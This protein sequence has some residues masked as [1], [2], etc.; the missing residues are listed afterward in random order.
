MDF[1]DLND[2]FGGETGETNTGEANYEA[3]ELFL[4]TGMD[5]AEANMLKDRK[6]AVI[7]LVDCS[8][9]MF[10]ANPHNPNTNSSIDQILK[11]A[12]SFMKSKI[13]T[14]DSDKIGLVLYG[15]QDSKNPLSFNNIYVL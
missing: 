2:A 1:D 12:L 6:D 15:C 7:F 11:A 13:I 3:E 5:Q 10:E 8:A 4:F 14:S 9:S